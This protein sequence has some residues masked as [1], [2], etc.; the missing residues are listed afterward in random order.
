MEIKLSRSA[1]LP[2]D[3][4]QYRVIKTGEAAALLGISMTHFRK[5]LRDGKL[6]APVVLD[7]RKLGWRVS[8]LSAWLETRVRPHNDNAAPVRCGRT[9]DMWAS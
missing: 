1:A 7:A 6:P 9:V 2:S 8:D 3:L 5:M 4:T